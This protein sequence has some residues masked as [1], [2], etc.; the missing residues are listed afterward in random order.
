MEPSRP[1]RKNDENNTETAKESREL[2]EPS[3]PSRINDKNDD[4]KSREMRD[5]DD[6]IDWNV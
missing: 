1:S 4:E 6:D 5:L 2:S 3:R